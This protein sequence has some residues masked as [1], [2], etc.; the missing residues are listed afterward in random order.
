MLYTGPSPPTIVWMAVI[1]K[2]LTIGSGNAIGQGDIFYSTPQNGTTFFVS[3]INGYTGSIVHLE[4]ICYPPAGN[5]TKNIFTLYDYILSFST[6]ERDFHCM[7]QS[8]NDRRMSVG[9]G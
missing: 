4:Y 8:T 9:C 1:D 2:Y 5:P 7:L 6:G 3:D